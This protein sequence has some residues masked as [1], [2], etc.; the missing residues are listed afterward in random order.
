MKYMT[1]AI[2]FSI[3]LLQQPLLFADSPEIMPLDEI[4]S[5]MIGTCSTIF[6]GSEIEEFDVEIIEIMRNFAPHSDVLLVRLLGP[7][8]EKTGVVAGMSGSPVYID[9]KLIGALCYRFGIFQKEPIGGVM[10]IEQMLDI[11]NKEKYRDQER[12]SRQGSVVFPYETALVGTAE[13]PATFIEDWTLK[14]VPTYSQNSALQPLKT[15]LTFSGFQ[16]TTINKIAPLFENYG[17]EV[18]TGGS[19]GTSS[20]SADAHA[21][22]LQPGDAVSGVIVDGDI[23]IHATG[24]VTYNNNGNVLAFGHPFF[25][26]GPVRIPMAKPKF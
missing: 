17:F 18:L 11:I 2:L 12:V 23:S 22:S 19:A 25:G 5:G 15:P 24:T 21:A 1:F 10:P 20:E 4:K 3:L 8:V 6:E 7:K 14:N 26:F 13:N 16:A 9:N